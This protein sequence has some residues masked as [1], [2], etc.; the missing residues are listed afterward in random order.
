MS[1]TP[2]VITGKPALR[3]GRRGGDFYASA[4]RLLLQIEQYTGPDH[5]PHWRIG[6]I[7]GSRLLA[8]DHST[9]VFDDFDTAAVC[10]EQMAR[11]AL[12]RALDAFEVE[13]QPATL[14]AD[15]GRQLRTPGDES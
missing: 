7:F 12:Q 4:G 2:R 6:F 14:R 8:N 9:R 1:N 15:R 11:K 13:E 5:K 10:A 3:W